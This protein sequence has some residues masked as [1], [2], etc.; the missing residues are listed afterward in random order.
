MGFVVGKQ[1]IYLTTDNGLL[2]VIDILSGKSLSK[3]KVDSRKISKP[4]IFNKN[5]YIV[6]DNSII[7]YN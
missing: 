6:K 7:K 5:L 2:I 4:Y 1:K 3:I